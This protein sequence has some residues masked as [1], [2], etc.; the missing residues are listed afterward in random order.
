M[1]V[2][3][4]EIACDILYYKKIY[5]NDMFLSLNRQESAGVFPG[6]ILNENYLYMDI[7]W[8]ECIPRL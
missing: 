2:E 7:S 1:I 6:E 4:G 5:M 8:Y 3:K